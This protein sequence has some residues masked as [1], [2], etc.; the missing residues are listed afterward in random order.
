MNKEK[1]IRILAA[2]V[3]VLRANG[4]KVDSPYDV[5]NFFADYCGYSALFE[6]GKFKVDTEEEGN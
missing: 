6:C 2:I 1:Q 5:K 3:D 4:V